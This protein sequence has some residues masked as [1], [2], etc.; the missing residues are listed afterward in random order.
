MTYFVS[1]VEFVGGFLLTVGF[2]SSAACLALLVDM[3]VAILTMHERILTRRWT[4]TR[5]ECLGCFR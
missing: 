3:L 5:Y 1:G 4:S 2:L